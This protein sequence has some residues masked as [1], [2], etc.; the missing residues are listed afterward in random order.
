[1]AFF[2]SEKSN[3]QV[4]N[5]PTAADN[6][7][8]PGNSAWV[9]ACGS[10]DYNTYYVNFTWG[11][12]LVNGDNEFILEL[13]DPSGDFT[14]PTPLDTI[15][16]KNTTFDFDFNFAL[17][18]DTGGDNYRMR[19]R[20]T[21]PAVIG[22]ESDPYP[23]YYIGYRDPILIS[24]DGDG[25]IPSGG[26]VQSCENGTVTLATHNVPNAENYSFNWF[27]GAELLEQTSNSITVSEPGVYSV[28]IDYGENCSGSA[29]TLSN[30]ITVVYVTPLN[31]SITAS[32][33]TNICNGQT[34]DLLAS[35][36]DANLF[37][38][39]YKNGTAITSRTLGLSSITVDANNADFE[40]VYYV[41]TEGNNSCTEQ[42]NTIEVTDAGVFSLTLQGSTNEILL[43][44]QTIDL[45]ADTDAN[46]PTYQWFRNGTAIAGATTNTY[47]ASE[48]GEYF[49]RVNQGGACSANS[50]DSNVITIATPD[51]FEFTISYDGS[52]Q[53]C[54]N[55]DITLSLSTI[56]AV[57][58]TDNIDVTTE[59]IN[60][61][62]YQW[63][64]DNT[65]IAGETSTTHFVLDNSFNGVYTLE[66]QLATYNTTS[67]SLVVILSTDE[68]IEIT[69]NG[70]AICD[71]D[72]LQIQTNNTINERSFEWLRNGSIYNSTDERIT[73]TETGAYQ[74]QIYDGDCILT[75]N[76]IDIVPFDDT[77]ITIDVEDEFLYVSGTTIPVTATGA[78]SYEWYD[79]QNNLIGTDAVY[80]VS[81]A[82]SYTVIAS[83]DNCNVSRTFTA[84][85]RDDFEVP[86]VITPN[87]DGIN[88]LWLLPNIYSGQQNIS[89]RIYSENGEEILDTYNYQNNWPE[90]T[91]SFPKQNMV[92]YYMIKELG[93]TI[94]QG[95]I[96]VIK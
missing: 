77:A 47:A 41:E 52:Y 7:D 57:F 75:S 73:V 85:L 94:K 61:F 15:S 45:T 84:I 39:W 63:N 92:F 23:M 38:T 28:E 44:G 33:D 71:G 16:D 88:D 56:T 89:V 18:E 9:Y 72:I 82:G 93:S 21:S 2:T 25:N 87:G 19:V 81:Q 91:T 35:E 86:N 8:L 67:N 78:T 69:S 74:L 22:D 40:G 12:P 60:D 59:L 76:V 24:K 31:I 3:A 32:G 83:V 90:S 50:E 30:S 54:T 17:P 49:I 14:D 55:T 48:E 1:M 26:Q 20:S 65:A 95:T 51:S 70:T 36:D 46:N 4:L 96:T 6:P 27:N 43:P 66:G 80:T 13:S 42:S 37:Y 68:E 34:V 29:N 11:P 62:T 79:E 58:G 64:V 10:E 5:A 53:D